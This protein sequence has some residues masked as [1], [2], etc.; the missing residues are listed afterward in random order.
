MQKNKKNLSVIISKKYN[1]LKTERDL[2]I[3]DWKEISEYIIPRKETLSSSSSPIEKESIIYDGTAG[4]ALTI[5]AAGLMSWTSPKSESWFSFAPSKNVSPENK[6]EAQKWLS[7]CTEKALE[8]LA[9]S[10]YYEKRHENIID[11]LAFGTSA[12]FIGKKDGKVYFENLDIGSYV[13]SENYLGKVDMVIRELKLKPYQALDFFGEKNIPRSVKEKIMKN[14]EEEDCYLHYVGSHYYTPNLKKGDKPFLSVYMHSDSK[15]VLK[16]GGYD[17]FPFVVGRYLTNVGVL[18]KTIWGYGPGFSAIPDVRQANYN[19]K[20]LDIASMKTIRP[21]WIVP[22]SFEGVLDVSPDAINYSSPATGDF[23]PHALNAV[24]DTSST[25]ESLMNNQNSIRNK[26][27]VD[28]WLT[29]SNRQYS[30][31]PTAEEI[32]ALQAEK[33]D[34]IS[35]AFDRDVNECISPLLTRCFELWSEEGEFPPPPEGLILGT[36]GNFGVVQTPVIVLTGKLSLAI[37]RMRNYNTDLQ[38]QRIAS[39]SQF[40]PEVLDRVNFDK[41][42][43]GTSFDSGLP[44]EYMRS[45]FEMKE[46]QNQRAMAQAEAMK[47][48]MLNEQLKAAPDSVKEEVARN[49][50]IM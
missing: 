12:M 45:D 30:T 41:L 31:P 50:G 17:S 20:L 15:E 11:K 29:I 4:E 3:N 37:K 6:M 47:A 8:L 35:P 42:V 21:P 9:E 22:D 39:I 19:R 40:N 28:L 32:R 2:L 26:F 46:L 13:F 23:E 44:A 18:K 7:Q 48:N 25:R 36:E 5:A 10:S 1:S 24:G 33:L 38:L 34:A 43:V 27:H 14:S 49:S 16:I